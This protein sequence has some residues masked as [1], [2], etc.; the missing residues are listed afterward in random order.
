MK[1]STLI[2]LCSTLIRVKL[3]IR[4]R[5]LVQA[6]QVIEEA[7][8]SQ[9]MRWP[10][11]KAN[12]QILLW[13]Q[14]SQQVLVFY[15]KKKRKKFTNHD[16]PFPLAGFCDFVCWAH[17]W[18]RH[19]TNDKYN[20]SRACVIFCCFVFVPLSKTCTAAKGIL[21]HLRWYINSKI[22]LKKSLYF[23]YVCYCVGL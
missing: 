7:G 6:L 13:V 20:Q 14:I 23:K 21:K 3:T 22:D 10:W 5:N 18:V 12:T 17:L 8:W 9:N 2:R 4:I 15:H 16:F 19:S 1:D 11:K